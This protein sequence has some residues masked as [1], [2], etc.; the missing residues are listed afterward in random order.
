MTGRD[1]QEAMRTR[2]LTAAETILRDE[3]S[4]HLTMRGLAD[5]ADVALRTLYNLYGSKTAILIA[6]LNQTTDLM[7]ASLKPEPTGGVIAEALD[8]PSLI[9]LGFGSDEPY[10]RALFWQIMT[11]GQDEE[12]AEAHE[13]IIDI[14]IGRMHLGES[15]A[16]LRPETDPSLLGRQL[17]LNLLSNL[18]SWAGGLMSLEDAMHHTQAVWASLLLTVIDAGL[19]PELVA[20][21]AQAQNALLAGR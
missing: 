5:K 3:G 16:E 13:R 21:L 20:R 19:R 1:S 8:M 10:F 17:G 14:V 12:R 18:G 4:A 6:L 2:I 15:A 11:S 7:V 9:Q